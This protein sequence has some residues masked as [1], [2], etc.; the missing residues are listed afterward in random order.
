MSAA[1]IKK[2]YPAEFRKAS[3]KL[4]QSEAG[5]ARRTLE[6]LAPNADQDA[7]TLFRIDSNE[8][9]Q[10]TAGPVSSQVVGLVPG[11]VDP[12]DIV[13]AIRG[14]GINADV[15]KANLTKDELR[16]LAQSIIDDADKSGI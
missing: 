3:G 6:R 9:L 11:D 1:D 7:T 10:V 12:K 16:K 14:Q 8:P 13:T 4:I 5:Q 15:L 2:A